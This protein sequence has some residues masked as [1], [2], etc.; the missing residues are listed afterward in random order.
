MGVGGHARLF[1]A[2]EFEGGWLRGAPGLASRQSSDESFNLSLENI[3]RRLVA[4]AVH[5]C[6]APKSFQAGDGGE[7]VVQD[8]GGSVEVEFLKLG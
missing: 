6:E 5:H 3:H 2:W 7:V 8:L 1:M 4:A